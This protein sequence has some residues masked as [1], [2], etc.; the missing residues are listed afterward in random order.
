MPKVNPEIMVWARETAGLSQKEAARK[1]GFK[2]SSRSTAAEK[3]AS[4][5]RGEKEPTRPQLVKMAGQY[6]RTRATGGWTSAPAGGRPNCDSS[7]SRDGL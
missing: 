4:I 3:L 6:R 1:L 2:N 7:D 5:E